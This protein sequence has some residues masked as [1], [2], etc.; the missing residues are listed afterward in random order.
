MAKIEFN[1]MKDKAKELARDITETGKDLSQKSVV[2]AK[3]GAKIISEQVADAKYEFDKKIINPVNKADLDSS[4]YT[5]PSLIQLIEYDKK[6]ANPVCKDALG[7]QEKIK[8]KA[9]LCLLNKYT[10]NLGIDFYPYKA[11][12]MYYKNPYIE[13]MYIQLD[14]YFK[15]IED[16]KVHE[17]EQIAQS[18]GAKRV[19][20]SFKEEKKN[21]ISNNAKKQGKL[22][23]PFNKQS[24]ADI[25]A[26]QDVLEKEF[27][28][29]KIASEIE[30]DGGKMP[31]K[32]ELVY[33]KENRDI[34]AL[35]AMRLEPENPVKSKTYEFHCGRGREM[36]KTEAAS[37]DFILEKKGLTGNVSLVSEVQAE[38]RKTLEYKIEF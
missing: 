36:Q 17:L 9:M 13:N 10:D 3:E 34:T 12:T 1:N 31:T 20:I 30:F 24:K 37:I 15:Y 11:E 27:S 6:M 32:P 23:I 16:A 21:L 25:V 7:F 29:I 8:D 22:K 26:K 28:N 2:K 35:I 18:L 5:V 19:K 14:S 38:Q 4:E 33:F